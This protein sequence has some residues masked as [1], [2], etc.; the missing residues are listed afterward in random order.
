M[1]ITILAENL[2][3][4]DDHFYGEPGVSYWVE[5]DG[6]NIHDHAPYGSYS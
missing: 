5:A 3:F 2:T 4:T 6:E 1:K